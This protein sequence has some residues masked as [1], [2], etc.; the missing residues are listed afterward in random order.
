MGF[1]FKQF[2][3]EDDRCAMKVGTDSIMLGSWAQVKNTQQVLDIGTGSGLLAIMLA[4]KMQG[5][6]PI[7]GID[8]SHAAIEQAIQNG[9]NCQWSEQLNFLKTR[10]QDFQPTTKYDL[11]ISNPPYFSPNITA[12]QL[13]AS[14]GRSSARQTVELEHPVLLQWV[15]DNLTVDGRF[16]CVLPVAVAQTVI[17][18]G[19]LIGLFCEH[20]LHVTPKPNGSISRVL[21]KMTR[22][23]GKQ[24][25][26]KITIYNE[27]KKYSDDYVTLCKEY[28]F[29]F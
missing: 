12:N 28:Y 3:I 5:M 22:K 24:K 1:R 25:I 10:L 19:R 11:I 17:E 13:N 9:Q 2:V 15:F 23:A 7:T 6:Y 21:L 26:T 27:L 18:H 29:N 8:I 4:Q 16:Y 20:T 14:K